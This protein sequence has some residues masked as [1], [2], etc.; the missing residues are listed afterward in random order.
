MSNLALIAVILRLIGIWL[1]W[2]KGSQALSLLRLWANSSDSPGIVLFFVQSTA[3]FFVGLLILIWPVWIA[4]LLTPKVLRYEDATGWLPGN[5]GA[6]ALGV[7]GIFF[8]V[9]TISS[10]TTWEVIFFLL[11]LSGSELRGVSGGQVVGIF[12]SLVIGIGLVWGAGGFSRML[13]FGRRARLDRK[14]SKEI[15]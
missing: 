6:V 9:T 12:V 10:P 7:T 8:I 15:K 4:R 3:S 11:G 5:F 13:A 2:T 14:I 1:V